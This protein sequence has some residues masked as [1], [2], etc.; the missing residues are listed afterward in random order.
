MGTPEYAL[1]TLEQLVTRYSV[2]GVVT[3]PDRPAGRGQALVAPPV[4]DFALAEG[5]PVFQPE[6]LRRLEA[7]EQIH[8]WAP[9]LIVVAAYGQI[10]RPAVLEIPRYGSLNIHASLLPRWRG[11]APVQGA[12]LAGDAVTGVTLM[13]MDEGMDTG[14]ILAQREIAIDPDEV[15]GELENRLAHLGASLLMEILPGYLQGELLPVPQPETG[16]TVTRRLAK[17]AAAIDWRIPAVD[18]HNQVRAFSPEPGAYA[19]W[20]GA[21]LKILRSAVVDSDL[22][23]AGAPGTVFRMSKTPIV[24]TGAGCLALLQVQMAGKRPMEGDLFMHGRKDFVGAILDS[25]Q[26]GG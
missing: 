14:P 7:V 26:P 24:V 9:D 21:R 17:E 3:Q 25:G 13:K 10:L 11:A 1:P 6:R 15:A 5:I 18:L 20:K 2:V 12:L 16:V 23:D 8:A 22:G 4:K 19:T